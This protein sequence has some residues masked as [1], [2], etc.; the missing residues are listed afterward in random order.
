MSRVRIKWIPLLLTSL[1]ATSVV[2]APNSSAAVPGAPSFSNLKLE[3]VVDN[4]YAAFYGDVNTVT[5]LLNQNNV[6][7]PTQRSNADSIAITPT[8]AETHLYIVPMGGG[9]REDYGGYLNGQDVISVAGAQVLETRTATGT[10]TKDAG[11]RYLRI[12]SY[13][14]GYNNT[15]VEAG[16]QSVTVAQMQ[17]LLNATM[18]WRSAVATNS[19]A[20]DGNV[21]NWQNS[22]VCCTAGAG[23][24]GKSWNFPTS[25]AVMFRYPISNL[26]L[27][28]LGGDQQVI[29]DWSAPI[30]GSAP[31]GYRIE[32]KKTGDADSTYSLYSN[33]SS[34][35]TIETVTGLINGIDY[36]FRVAATNADGIGPFSPVKSAT[37]FGANISAPTISGVVS[38]G[39]TSA[40]T[41]NQSFTG[42]VQFRVDGK[43]IPGCIRV[44]QTGVQPNLQAT[45]NWKPAVQGA[46][47]VTTFI[48]STDSNYSSILSQT[49]N[50]QVIKR[51]TTR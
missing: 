36:S 38:K 12:E 30:G 26:A 2:T 46:R 45:C 7:W 40:I 28:V 49:R 8:T 39:V 11:S 13:I 31:T 32:Y 33:V 29:V 41:S 5:R 24:S 3:I 37:S 14:A 44:A 18:G 43:K 27:P 34:A 25:S 6:G 35:V 1:V 42:F 19:T 20:G 23:L 17:T 51:T 47:S 48:T 22:P 15:S 16:T 50:V 21:P 9:G 4:D 10:T